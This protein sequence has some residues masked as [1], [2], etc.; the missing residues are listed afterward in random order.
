LE[1]SPILF[2]FQRS[3]LFSKGCHFCT[4]FNLLLA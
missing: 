2:S 3:N 1:S 4:S